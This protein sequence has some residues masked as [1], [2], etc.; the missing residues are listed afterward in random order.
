MFD[1]V[2]MYY[3]NKKYLEVTNLMRAETQ[4]IKKKPCRCKF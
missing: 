3:L 2:L 1:E 4:K